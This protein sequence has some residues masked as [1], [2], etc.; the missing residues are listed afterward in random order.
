[1]QA[2]LISGY[3]AIVTF[4]SLLMRWALH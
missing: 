3:V 4:L 2:M 1:M